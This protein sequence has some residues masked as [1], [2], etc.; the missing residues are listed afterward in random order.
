MKLLGFLFVAFGV[1][2]YVTGTFMGTDLTGVSWSP[3]A[4]GVIGGV[5]MNAGG[6]KG[7]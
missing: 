1:V 3:I 5:L 4:A 6:K 2:D 7:G